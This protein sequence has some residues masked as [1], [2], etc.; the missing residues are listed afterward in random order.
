MRVPDLPAYRT[1][2]ES[3]REEWDTF[4]ELCRIPISRVYRDRSVFEHLEH[5]VLPAFAEAAAAQGRNKLACWSPCCAS[6]EDTYT[7]AL[8]WRLRVNHTSVS[9]AGR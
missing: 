4:D 1:Y 3:H 8:L 9:E 5:E 7:L 2:V 6:G